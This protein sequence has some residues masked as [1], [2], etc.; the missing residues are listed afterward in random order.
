MASMKASTYRRRGSTTDHSPWG[1]EGFTK[2]CLLGAV[3]LSL[4]CPSL[5]GVLYLLFAC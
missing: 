1:A 3:A 4:V 2:T 5:D